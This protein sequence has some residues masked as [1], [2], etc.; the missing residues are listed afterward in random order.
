MELG[1]EVLVPRLGLPGRVL[2][3]RDD[4]VE[5]EVLGRR[6]HMPLRELEGA[7][8]PTSAERRAAQAGATLPR[9]RWPRRAATCRFSWTCAACGATRPWSGSSSTWKMRRWRACA[10]ARIVHGKGTGAIRQAVRERLRRASTWPASP[11]SPTPAAAT[12]PPRSGS[13]SR[14][15]NHTLSVMRFTAPARA[16]GHP[17]CMTAPLLWRHFT[18][19]AERA[20]DGHHPGRGGVLPGPDRGGDPGCAARH[21]RARSPRPVAAYLHPRAVVDVPPLQVG[22]R[23][24]AC[25]S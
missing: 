24:S 14:K 8:R 25:S 7:T 11:P 1:A 3:I 23:R 2:A 21:V 13:S 18:G 4:T 9:V 16:A 6:V 19:V 20:D 17:R 5:V 10:E 15:A 12:A 22:G